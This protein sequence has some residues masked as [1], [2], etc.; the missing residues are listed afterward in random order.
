MGLF[1]GSQE[2]CHVE[3]QRKRK[4]IDKLRW[5]NVQL[6]MLSLLHTLVAR[7]RSISLCLS[8]VRKQMLATFF[9][10]KPDYSDVLIALEFV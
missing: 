8:R 9:M 1:D 6:L 2:F 3:Q 5:I 4:T 7:S 10:A